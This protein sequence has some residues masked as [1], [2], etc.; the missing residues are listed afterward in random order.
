MLLWKAVCSNRLLAHVDLVLFLNKCDLLARKLGAGTRLAKYV[1]SYGDRSNDVDTASKCA[2]LPLS[3]PW[4]LAVGCWL[5]VGAFTRA[6]ADVDVDLAGQIF[7]ASLARSSARTRPRRASSTAF[8]RPSRCVPPSAS[9]LS[10]RARPPVLTTP[11]LWQDT[12]TTAG[13][14]ISGAWLSLSLPRGADGPF[15]VFQHILRARAV[16]DIV[17]RQHLRQSKLV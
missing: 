15:A 3:P 2:C 4:L 17:L 11:R 5:F 8:A 10:L 7:G 13:I 6:D 1:R 14:L 12:A 16:R 9:L